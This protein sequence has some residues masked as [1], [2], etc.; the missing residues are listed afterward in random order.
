MNESQ[1]PEFVHKE[2]HPRPRLAN[3]FAPSIS[4]DTLGSI[5][6]GWFL[7]VA[8][9]QQKESGASRFLARIEK[10]VDSNPPRFG[11]SAKSIVKTRSVGESM[12]SGEA[13]ESSRFFQ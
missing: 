2:I 3:H 9:E 13:R 5:F 8:G 4:C 7:P 1:F 6:C 11:C 10:L 12:F